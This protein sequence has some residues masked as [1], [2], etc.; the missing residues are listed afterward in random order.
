MDRDFCGRTCLH[1]CVSSHWE[2][3]RLN[4][5]SSSWIHKHFTGIVLLIQHG[6]DVYAEDYSGRSVSDVAYRYGLSYELREKLGYPNEDVWDCALAVCGY[7]I[8]DFRQH[9]CRKAHY[10]QIYKRQD[11]E[12]L[13][14]GHEHLCP[15]YDDEEYS[16]M[17]E[18]SRVCSE[19]ESEKEWMTTD[20]E[21]EGLDVGEGDLD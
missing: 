10:G 14:D 12:K 15:Y 8:L 2:N 1:H 16:I 3:G 17:V 18:A 7:N 6:A 11:F 21:D 20:S 9:R 13:W 4:F 5:D 19:E